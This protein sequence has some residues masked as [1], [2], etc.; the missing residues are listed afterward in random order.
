[1]SL[2][3][4]KYWPLYILAGVLYVILAGIIG[5]LGFAIY[6]MWGML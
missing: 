1:M 4:R 2:E 5:F 3:L 6:V